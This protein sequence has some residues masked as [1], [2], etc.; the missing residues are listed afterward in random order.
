[1][2]ICDREVEQL[3]YVDLARSDT[4]SALNSQEA[5]WLTWAKEQLI[6]L[7]ELKEA[8]DSDCLP[9]SPAI[10]IAGEAVLQMVLSKIPNLCPPYIALEENGGL[11]FGWRRG[12]KSIDIEIV[13][14]YQ[15]QYL[16][17]DRTGSG[18][19]EAGVLLFPTIPIPLLL[20]F[21]E[22]VGD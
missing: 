7:R 10:M 19:E 4:D 3:N 21:T 2:S 17:R 16:Y 9:L 22:F 15:V 20:R 11:L 12:P 18:Q 5:P 8:E 13:S 14:R 1:M 6:E